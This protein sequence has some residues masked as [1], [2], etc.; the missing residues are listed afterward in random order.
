MLTEAKATAQTCKA[1]KSPSSNQMPWGESPVGIYPRWLSWSDPLTRTDLV[2]G[3]TNRPD[4]WGGLVKS[5]ISGFFERDR[6]RELI[7]GQKT[8]AKGD[9]DAKRRPCD[10]DRAPAA[11]GCDFFRPQSLHLILIG[12]AKRS[13]RAQRALFAGGAG[14]AAASVG[15][16]DDDKRETKAVL[17]VFWP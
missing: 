13:S 11:A 2:R 12:A 17:G 8:D 10:F 4:N 15:A 1:Y 6:I 14:G 7:D 5:L 3:R 9:F 16:P